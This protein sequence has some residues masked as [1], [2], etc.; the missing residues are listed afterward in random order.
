MNSCSYL[1]QHR[2][3]A[4]DVDH[5]QKDILRVFEFRNSTVIH[6]GKDYRK[7]ILN[8]IKGLS[9][10]SGNILAE[11]VI[12]D[13]FEDSTLPKGVAYFPEFQVKD[14]KYKIVIAY[15]KEGISDPI[16]T[17]ELINFLLILRNERYFLSHF[18]AF[19]M[20]YNAM[21]QDPVAV[22]N[23][24][25]IREVAALQSLTIE[26]NDSDIKKALSD[27]GAEWAKEKETYTQKEGEELKRQSERDIKRR[28]IIAALDGASED[29]QL[30]TLIANN[31][32]AGVVNLLRKYLS[33]EQ[34]A[35]FEKKYWESYLEIIQNPLPLDKR[36]LLYRGNNDDII[37]SAFQEGREL[38][39]E[40]AKK[41]GKVFMMSTI[42]TKNQGSWNRR[43][44]SLTTMFKKYVGT[45]WQ[46]EDEFTKSARMSTMFF[47]H[48]TNPEGSPF[49][50]LTPKYNIARLYGDSKLTAYALDPRLLSFN[51]T[52]KFTHELEFLI[53][54]FIFPEDVAAYSFEMEDPEINLSENQLKGIFKQKLVK[55]HGEQTGG[56][57]YTKV[58]NN[59][60]EFFYPARNRF[61]IKIPM[62]PIVT[63]PTFY[64]KFFEKFS[65]QKDEATSS[66]AT[67]L[68]S[69]RCVDLIAK[70]WR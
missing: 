46:N 40:I 58:L 10:F 35:P 56:E 21:E 9:I 24:A 63:E 60:L 61:V 23:W 68:K 54:L 20:Y 25:K 37:Y 4:E 3:P 52:S 45:N 19:E 55:V 69:G 8:N 29:H 14:N 15:S 49:L 43:L 18:S 27:R 31:D 36:I 47:K 5:S 7:M 41:E 28:E 62:D 11:N 66:D 6:A 38:N 42:L 1:R 2:H 53:P 22:K 51:F 70:F 34:M 65:V 13:F 12:V 57:I 30:K 48:S 26:L 67:A 64:E 33:W 32:R 16:A 44:R 59:S 50:S 17:A 39:K